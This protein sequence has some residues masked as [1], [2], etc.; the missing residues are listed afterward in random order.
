MSRLR[1]PPGER[2]ARVAWARLTEPCDR[3]AVE[4]IERVGAEEA[5]HAVQRETALARRIAPRLEL[6]DVERELAVARRINARVLIPGDPDWPAGLASLADPPHCLWVRGGHDLDE[7][8]QRSVS[9]VGAR[10]ATHYGLLQA[11]DLAEGLADRGFTIVSG[12]AYGIDGA[13]HRGALAAG[14]LTVAVLAGG[15]ERAYPT[16]HT[17]LLADIVERGLVVSELPPGSAPTKWRFLRRNRLIATL[18]QGTIIV[19]AGLRSGSGSTAREAE[20]HHR[21]VCAVPG[22]VTSVVSAGCHQL[23]RDGAV[24]VTDA[25]E[26][27]EAVG[28]I[29]GDLAPEKRGPVRPGDDL[30]ELQGAVFAALP[31]RR[32][33][34]ADDL[35]RRCA[36][37]GREVLAALGTLEA[38]GLARREGSRWR[39]AS[40]QVTAA[41]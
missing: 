8:C 40:G 26:A 6:L 23:I 4:L 25:A 15:V 41:G 11:T 36:R 3:Q 1:V 28:A 33:T 34:D 10:S 30:D 18:T 20:L 14:G 5:L 9:V 31:V 29:G 37:D 35:A 12:A 38:L 22:P 19:E 32:A 17:R 24:L 27:A 7:V 2:A 39:K 16:G 21:V 13:A